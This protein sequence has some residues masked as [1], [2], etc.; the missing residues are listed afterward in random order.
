MK[1]LTLLDTLTL[2]STAVY[3]NPR[4]IATLKIIYGDLTNSFIPCEP[5]D[6]S[7]IIFHAS[8]MPMQAITGVTVEGEPQSY[9]YRAMTAHQDETG[10]AIAAV[11]FDNPQYDKAVAI[12]GKGVMKESTGELIENPADFISH[13]FLSVQGYDSG[14]LD[15]PELANFYSDCLGQGLKVAFVLEDAAATIKQLMDELAL[16]LHAQA[17][18]SD[19]RS[20]MR[21][22]GSGSAPAVMYKFLQDDIEDFSVSSGGL[23]NEITAR[24]AWDFVSG[25]P[26]ASITKHAPLSKL[27]YGVAPK[28]L[29]LRM[30]QTTRQAERVCDAVLA[31]SALP[32]IT[33]SF[34]HDLRSLL[35]EVGD[36]ISISH[37][38]GLG[39]SGWTNAAGMVTKKQLAGI[40]IGYEVSMQ[41]SGA[42]SAPELLTL[43]MT[44]GTGKG[45]LSVTYENGVATIT[46]YADVQGSPPIEGAEVTIGGV[47]KISDK[48]G[49]VRFELKRGTYTALMHASGYEDSE[50]TFT[51]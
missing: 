48:K 45:S 11:I 1:R 32:E 19:G 28:T 41:P 25:Q 49:Q 14:S 4:R 3:K 46:I 47:K 5:L 9:G 36:G 31:T 39:E 42:L 10:R 51:V 21:L 34:K 30:A 29:D 13:F 2:R 15:S 33:A 50:I 16:N 43:T 20:V 24:F 27:L 7:G 18:I 23:C 22:K 40:K 17:C 6:K 26:T 35:V 37:E 12:S 44:A 38:A 8:D